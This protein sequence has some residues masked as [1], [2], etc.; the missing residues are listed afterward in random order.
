MTVTALLKML[1]RC[2]VNDK[3]STTVF[4]CFISGIVLVLI[5]SIVGVL[6]F[7][8]TKTQ[9]VR[10]GRLSVCAEFSKYYRPLYDTYRLFYYIDRD[11]DR[12]QAGINGYFLGNQE[13]MPGILRLTPSYTEVTKKYYAIDNRAENIV[14]QMKKAAISGGINNFLEKDDY[15]TNEEEVLEKVEDE[16]NELKENAHTENSVLMLLKIIEGINVS[17]GKITASEE[18]VK[19]LIF[20]EAAP[21]VVGIDSDIVWKSVKDNYYDAG[22]LLNK[23]AGITKK[24]L[25]G[26]KTSFPS[27]EL[28][29]FK[30]NITMVRNKSERAYE[31]ANDILSTTAKEAGENLICDVGL[32]K[33]LLAKNIKI[34]DELELFVAHKKPGNKKEWELYMKRLNKVFDIVEAYSVSALRFDYSTLTLSECKDPREELKKNVSGIMDMLIDD[35]TELSSKSVRESDIYVKLMKEEVKKVKETKEYKFDNDFDCFSDFIGNC[36]ENL[37]GSGNSKTDESEFGDKA[38]IISYADLYFNSFCMKDDGKPER[39]ALEYEKEYI[40]AGNVS[41]RK[42]LK[43]VIYKLLTGRTGMSFAAIVSDSNCRNKA[44][45]TA[46]QFVGFS[47]MQSLVK[48]VQ[49]S[50]IAAWAY[51]DACV[52][53]AILLAGKKIPVTKGKNINISYEQMSSFGEELIKQKVAENN[54][55]TG[56]NYDKWLDIMLFAQKK[57][58]TLYRMLDLIQNNIKLNYDNRFSF[59]NA[60]YGA[61]AQI[62]CCEPYDCHADISFK[63]D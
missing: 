30:D 19:K 8:W 10:S 15:I 43:E 46:Q 28:N 63:Y 35:E 60:V 12:M 1:S 13:N 62:G 14:V 33:E 3:G 16:I 38:G 57:T 44:Y 39:W 23:L 17:E 55:S 41:D 51:E 6:R 2:K 32:I 26:R 5:L 34:L 48:V 20:N 25:E 31:I 53:V 36:K 37:C 24:A 29:E 7:R 4:L 45:I 61:D 52:D 18:F 50:I 11:E 47:G 40:I 27:K 58:V 21:S 59:Q 56:I 49:Y 9:I 54:C 42:N 22:K